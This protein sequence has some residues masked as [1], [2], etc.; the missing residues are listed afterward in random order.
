MRLE[1]QTVK[2]PNYIDYLL[3]IA[4]FALCAIM[5]LASLQSGIQ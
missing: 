3:M 5:G 4:L 1:C 2:A